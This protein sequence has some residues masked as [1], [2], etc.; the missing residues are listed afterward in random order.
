MGPSKLRSSISLTRGRA[1]QALEGGS[2]VVFCPHKFCN[3]MQFRAGRPAKLGLKMAR[4]CRFLVR[5]RA[6]SGIFAEKILLE[7]KFCGRHGRF[8]RAFWRFLR[9][10]KPRFLSQITQKSVVGTR[11]RS[12]RTNLGASLQKNRLFLWEKPDSFSRSPTNFLMRSQIF[13]VAHNFFYTPT[14]FLNRPQI[15]S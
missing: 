5:F 10:Q 12:L 9:G 1:D 6:S 4:P 7:Y 14:N 11:P 8:L 2:K 3:T 15:F 13:S